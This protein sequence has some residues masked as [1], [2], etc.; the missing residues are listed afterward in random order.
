MRVLIISDTME[1]SG[2]EEATL[3]LAR[4]LSQQENI[5]VKLC[6]T[7]FEDSA[8]AKLPFESSILIGR[9]KPHRIEEL[10]GSLANPYSLFRMVRHCRR[11][12]EKFQPD[13][14]HSG[15]FLSVIPSL[16]IAR[17]LKV[18]VVAHIH[19]YRILSLIDMPFLRGSVF[20]PS[21]ASELRNYLQ[22]VDSYHALLGLGLRRSLFSLYNR[23]DLIIA[24]SNF[25]KKSMSRFLRPPVR[26]LYNAGYDFAQSKFG[27]KKSI[28]P[29]VL[30][31]GRLSVAKGFPKFLEAAAL[32]LREIDAEIHI[33]G[34]GDLRPLAV[35]FA[36]THRKEA[37][38]H[39]FLPNGEF[40]DL[41]SR[42]HLTLHPSLSPEPCPLSVI[43]SVNLG[44]TAMASNRGGLPELL[45]SKYLFDP[46]AGDIRDK[47]LQFFERPEDYPPSLAVDVDAGSIIKQLVDIYWNVI[48]GH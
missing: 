13:V 47:V 1:F 34:S 11:V 43:K 48:K 6:S 22:M 35:Q 9:N 3:N 32:L 7:R 17:R 15:V 36:E 27:G 39:G 33:T 30:F 42:S 44:T 5:E 38:F 18:P 24:V 26:V 8:M 4:I 16:L 21:Y 45:P 25:V 37:Y 2:A 14:V 28:K 40:Y 29:T 46:I 10:Y 31:C 20:L 19:D 41:V 12:A 23:C